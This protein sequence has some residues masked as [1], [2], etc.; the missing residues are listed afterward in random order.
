MDVAKVVAAIAHSGQPIAEAYGIGNLRG[1]RLALAQ[2]P[3]TAGTG[4]EVTRISILTAADSTKLGIVSDTLYADRVLLD[5]SL[6]AGLPALHTAATGI[7]AMV[8]AIEAYTSVH[9][10]NPMSDMFAREAL[11]LLSANL[12]TVCRNGA[13]IEAREAMLLGS[14]LA[15]QAFANAPVAAVHALAYPLGGRFHIPHGLAY[16]RPGAAALYAELA[17]VLGNPRTGDDDADAQSFIASMLALVEGSNAPR[18]LRDVGVPH[19][20]LPL[21]AADAMKQTRLL[22]NNPVPVDEAAALT[23]YEQAY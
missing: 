6:T 7:D 16:N 19:D 11:K 1:G 20:A 17:V 4:S 15:G 3:T 22:V 13:D 9:L 21:L 8:H 12:L 18:R 5:A 23:M 10:K 2:V 14:M